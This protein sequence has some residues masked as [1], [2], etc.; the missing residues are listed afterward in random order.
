MTPLY[1]H[2]EL[3]DKRLRF[4]FGALLAVAIAVAVAV[5]IATGGIS[6]VPV[7]RFLMILAVYAALLAVI[8]LCLGQPR[9]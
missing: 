3:Q 8:R 1:E 9:R 5:G 4:W 2:L 6:I 7:I